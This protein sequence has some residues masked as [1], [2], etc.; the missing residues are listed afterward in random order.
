M[1]LAYLPLWFHAV[2]GCTLGL[3]FGSLSWN[4][5]RGFVKPAIVYSLAFTASF[6]FVSGWVALLIGALIYSSIQSYKCKNC[7]KDG[8]K[9]KEISKEG[10]KQCLGESFVAPKG[11]TSMPDLII[12]SIIL[13]GGAIFFGSAF[14]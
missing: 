5:N 14:L 2:M 8:M 10:C 4:K 7:D 12:G 1:S 11:F 6:S 3:F 9:W 13:L